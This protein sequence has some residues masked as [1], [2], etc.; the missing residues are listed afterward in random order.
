MPEPYQT[1]EQ[2]MLIGKVLL[3]NGLFLQKFKNVAMIIRVATV[4][5]LF[6]NIK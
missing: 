6:Y 5:K 1:F 4:S 3:E 2:H